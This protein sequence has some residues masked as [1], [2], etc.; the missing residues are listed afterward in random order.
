MQP[1]ILPSRAALV[2]RIELQFEYGQNLICLVGASGLGKSYLAE[3]FITDKYPEF[4][5]AFVKLS[6][7]TKDSDLTVQ[8]L[9]NSFRSPLIDQTVSL[10]DNFISL[11]NES[12]SGPCLWVLDGARHLSDE[13]IY[14]LQ[15][16]AKQTVEKVYIL[17]TAQ[18]PLMVPE[19]LDL[20]LEHLSLSESKTLMKMF[21]SQL[22]INEDPIFQTFLK[23]S[24]GNPALLL[25]WRPAEQQ[26]AQPSK[27][28]YVKAQWH[29]T[30]LTI[31]LALV[32][33]AFVYKK[34]ISQWLPEQN[35]GTTVETVISS[36]QVFTEKT[37]NDVVDS[38]SL[39]KTS[40]NSGKNGDKTLVEISESVNVIQNVE[41]DQQ[42]V[43]AVLSALTN[44]HDEVNL[45]IIEGSNINTVNKSLEQSLTTDSKIKTKVARSEEHSHTSLLAQPDTNWAIQLL[46]VKE[47][48]IADAFITKNKPRIL[49]LELYGT[50]RLE[51]P[52]WIVVQS[53]FPTLESAKQAKNQLPSDILAGQ[54]FFKKQTKIK[55]EITEFAR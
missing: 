6:A 26:V 22:P 18:S 45:S 31:L 51:T 50:H 35:E 55:Q 38:N 11:H 15:M 41:L 44:Q 48:G 54:P 4:N 20:H 3:S 5:K 24:R 46:A 36:E 8:L 43:A 2:N 39:Q 27:S 25:N 7:H 16:L 49:H 12:S 32:M 29:L 17:I 1:Q 14:Q 28:K 21:F 19:A 30:L 40:S 37:V 42:N 10:S 34:E 23:E 9:Q 53:G 52:W 33:I 47:K 13:M